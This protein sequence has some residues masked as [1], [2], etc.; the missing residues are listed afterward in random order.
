[1]SWCSLAGFAVD[2]A[3]R[4]EA[5]YNGVLEISLFEAL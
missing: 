3:T 5:D 4:I 2:P 1:M